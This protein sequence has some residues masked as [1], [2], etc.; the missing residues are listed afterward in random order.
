MVRVLKQGI[1][2][3][4]TLFPEVAKEAYGWDPSLILSAVKDKKEWRCAHGHR[5]FATVNHRTSS[6][7]KCPYCSRKLPIK[8]VND[9]ATLFPSIAAEAYGWDPSDYLPQSNKKKNWKCACGHIWPASIYMR[10]HRN[11]GCP[12]CSTGGFDPTKDAWMY[13]IERST[14]F[15]IGITNKPKNRLRFHRRYGWSLIQIAGPMPGHLVADVELKIK[16][17]LKKSNLRIDGSHES[18]RKKD[19]YAVSLQNIALTAGVDAADSYWL[20]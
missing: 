4:A 14:E 18:W 13:F 11:T 7:T 19:Y 2:D 17:W 15:K 20:N 1:N 16:K 12:A 3:L 9:L 10:S 8:G 6:K 5:W